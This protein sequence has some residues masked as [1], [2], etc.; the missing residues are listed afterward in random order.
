VKYVAPQLNTLDCHFVTLT[1]VEP[2]LNTLRWNYVHFTLVEH[3]EKVQQG[4][5]GEHREKVQQGGRD[6]PATKTAGKTRL[7]ANDSD[8]VLE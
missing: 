2:Q 8:G 5:R 6:N 4:R 1:P 7:L 3:R